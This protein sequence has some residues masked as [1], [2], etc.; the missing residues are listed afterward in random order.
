[1]LPGSATL[2]VILL[3]V[4]LSKKGVDTLITYGLAIK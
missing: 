4:P 3:P 2:L 1:M